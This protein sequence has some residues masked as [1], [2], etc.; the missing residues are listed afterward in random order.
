M[1]KVLGQYVIIM[2]KFPNHLK[3]EKQVSNPL[4]S[5]YIISFMLFTPLDIR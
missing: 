3:S 5:I 1:C 4:R 2:S